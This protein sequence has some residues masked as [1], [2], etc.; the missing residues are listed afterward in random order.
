MCPGYE[1]RW[2]SYQVVR[3]DGHREDFDA[4]V[5]G[6]VHCIFQAAAWLLVALQRMPISYHDQVFVLLQVGAPGEVGS[7]KAPL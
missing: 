2:E 3:R 7:M 5:F 1:R 6:L 4:Q